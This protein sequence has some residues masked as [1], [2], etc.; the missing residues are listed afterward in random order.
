[1]DFHGNS[2]FLDIAVISN[3]IRLSSLS[4]TL[5]IEADPGNIYCYYHTGICFFAARS[6]FES[7]VTHD[8]LFHLVESDDLRGELST[9]LKSHPNLL[10]ETL[11]SASIPL[12]R[13]MADIELTTRQTLLSCFAFSDADYFFR[14]DIELLKNISVDSQVREIIGTILK[15]NFS[16]DHTSLPSLL[17]RVPVQSS[18]PPSLKQGDSSTS[19]L[20]SQINGQ[21][22]VRQI[23]QDYTAAEIKEVL[24]SLKQLEEDGSITFLTAEHLKAMTGFPGTEI[25]IMAHLEIFKGIIPLLY[26]EVSSQAQFIQKAPVQRA[27][28]RA[29]TIYP[30]LFGEKNSFQNIS[31]FLEDVQAGLATVAPPEKITVLKKGLN[32]FLLYLIIHLRVVCSEEVCTSSIKKVKGFLTFISASGDYNQKEIARMITAVITC[33]QS[34]PAKIEFDESPTPADNSELRELVARG[35]ILEAYDRLS[36]G[37]FDTV[38]R[39][40]ENAVYRKALDLFKKEIGPKTNLINLAPKLDL[41][42]TDVDLDSEDGYLL[43][44]LDRGTTIQELIAVTGMTDI[45]I[46]RRLDKLTKGGFITI[47]QES[48]PIPPS[49]KEPAPVDIAAPSC[50]EEKQ[51][52]YAAVKNDESSEFENLDFSD[53]NYSP[54]VAEAV[55]GLKLEYFELKSLSPAEIFGLSAQSTQIDFENVLFGLKYRY[56]PENFAESIKEA[57]KPIL[58]KIDAHID[59]VAQVIA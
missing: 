55:R 38:D 5:E 11:R 30:H 34:L 50:E 57:V 32:A 43:S 25:L 20:Y 51:N 35:K 23:L 37:H 52:I 58:T 27:F 1:M 40:L 4:G 26:D 9:F 14:E 33:A 47:S 41:D 31:T 3:I 46:Y 6:T 19:R 48:D 7:Y 56:D 15:A 39:G 2:K 8:L 36:Q 54:E 29:A 42:D 21:S 22:S 17:S 24:A 10:I 13:I 53:P 18:S 44:R 28:R 16:L 49:E 45:T 59:E 12:E